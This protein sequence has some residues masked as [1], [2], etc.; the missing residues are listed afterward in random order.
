MTLSFTKWW[1]WQTMLSIGT[2]PKTQAIWTKYCIY[3]YPC[4]LSMCTV[5]VSIVLHSVLPKNTL[6]T[7]HGCLNHSNLEMEAECLT[8]NLSYLNLNISKTKKK[9]KQAIKSTRTRKSYWTHYFHFTQITDKNL[10]FPFKN[11]RFYHLSHF[12][13]IHEALWMQIFVFLGPK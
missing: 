8:K 1:K 10:Q 6:I 5:L 3:I 7:S 12:H 11:W 4:Y 2:F 9:C 13:S